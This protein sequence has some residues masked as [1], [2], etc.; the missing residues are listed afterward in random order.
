[1]KIGVAIPCY[2]YHIPALKRCLDSI[3]KQS[4]KPDIVVV[5]CSSCVKEDI[6]IEYTFYSYPI[7]FLT[8]EKRQN[9]SKNRNIASMKC[10]EEGMDYITYIDCDDEMHPQ[11][12]EMLK[13]AIDENK[14]CEFIIHN[15]YLESECSNEFKKINN[16][17]FYHNVLK[18]KSDG[19]GV[20]L[21][22]QL[23]EKGVPNGH[24][25]QSTV[26]KRLFLKEMYNESEYYE[27]KEDSFFCANCL[28]DPNIKTTYIYDVLSK[29]YPEGKTIF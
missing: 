25:A 10:I 14:E 2:K 28:T 16:P 22:I 6:P 1:M 23:N 7:I 12:I 29:Y 8:T 11:R 4:I 26:S 18:R 24:H 5:S 15:F 13:R 3:E 19:W 21:S 20:D 27:R 17:S 9:A